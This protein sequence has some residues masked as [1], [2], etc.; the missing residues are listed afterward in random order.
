LELPTTPVRS[1]P[2]INRSECGAVCFSLQQMASHGLPK[3]DTGCYRYREPLATCYT[4]YGCML[5]VTLR[6]SLAQSTITARYRRSKFGA[7]L[8]YLRKSPKIGNLAEYR[9]WN[10]LQK[11]P[12]TGYVAGEPPKINM[13]LA[14][15]WREK[16]SSSVDRPTCPAY[17]SRYILAGC[18]APASSSRF[19]SVAFRFGQ[20]RRAGSGSRSQS[21]VRLTEWSG[22]PT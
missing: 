20:L 21:L 22:S 9:V 14:Q 10:D 5:V 2:G 7:K 4:F 6:S 18:P 1:A 16:L 8:A 3:T 11:T 13:I 19:N 15:F 12:E 17:N